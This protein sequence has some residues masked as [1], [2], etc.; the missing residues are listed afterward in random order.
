MWVFEFSI[1][2]NRTNDTIKNTDPIITCSPWNP[3]VIKKTLPKEESDMQKGASRYS[4]PCS[5]VKIAPKVIVIIS[6]SVDLEKSFFN[7]SWWD[8]VTVTPED[9]SKIVFIRGILIGLKVI[10]D[11]EGQFCPSSIVGEIL[12]W[13][14]A[15]KKD[16]KNKTS[17]TINKTIPIFSPFMTSKECIPW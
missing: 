14:N 1:F 11:K 5:I 17:E 7:I 6:G 13:K 15:Q 16:T 3:V 10:I 2:I 8:H 12:L 4:N 9:R